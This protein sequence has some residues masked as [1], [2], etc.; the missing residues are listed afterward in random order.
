MENHGFCP[1]AP[2]IVRYE[3]RYLIDKSVKRGLCVWSKASAARAQ[4]SF[5]DTSLY[6]ISILAVA[7]NMVPTPFHCTWYDRSHCNRLCYTP[8]FQCNV[9]C[10]ASQYPMVRVVT[11]SVIGK[12]LRL[13][14]D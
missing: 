12:N 13:V 9:D 10:W 5:A 2:R 1:I 8:P 14:E 6:N 7:T 11:G 3:N 4:E